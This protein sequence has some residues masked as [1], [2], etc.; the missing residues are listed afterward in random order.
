MAPRIITIAYLI[1]GIFPCPAAWAQGSP[2]E[3]PTPTV[4]TNEAASDGAG[5]DEGSDDTLTVRAK[6]IVQGEVQR[7]LAVVKRAFPSE[8]HAAGCC[9][10]RH[11]PLP[12]TEASRLF[13]GG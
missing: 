4:E 12:L 6:R 10:Q 13:L 3:M 7:W 2:S 1:L 8:G 9:C 5:Q 11:A